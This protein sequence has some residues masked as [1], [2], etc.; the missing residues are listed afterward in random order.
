MCVYLID[1]RQNRD[2]Q[3]GLVKTAVTIGLHEMWDIS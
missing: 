2:L 1:P 3:Q